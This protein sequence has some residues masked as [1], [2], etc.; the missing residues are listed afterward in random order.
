V[1]IFSKELDFQTQVKGGIYTQDSVHNIIKSVFNLTSPKFNKL[2][3]K[4][5][6]KRRNLYDDVDKYAECFDEFFDS[7][8]A[9]LGESFHDIFEF[10]DIDEKIW[11]KSLEIH[12]HIGEDKE[13][14]LFTNNI[15]E[16]MRRKLKV[17]NELTID[18]IK[19]PLQGQVEYIKTR[20]A[21]RENLKMWISKLKDP[22][23][24]KILL[25]LRSL[26]YV[27]N[28]YMIEEED[29]LVTLE[30]AETYKNPEIQAAKVYFEQALQK[31]E[32]ERRSLSV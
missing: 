15:F 31:L 8:N 22:L 28:T 30:S 5:Q 32:S 29:Y 4:F 16:F 3:S 20:V 27:Y 2:Y 13:I 1:K 23:L 6:E 18:D 9:I 17:K 12:A 7:L 25:K 26:D 21:D 24:L 10:K 11:E 14:K 19:K